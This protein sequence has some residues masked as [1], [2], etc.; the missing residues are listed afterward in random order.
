MAT[1]A[2][3]QDAAELASK[4]FRNFD[5]LLWP[6]QGSGAVVAD[7]PAPPAVL[8]LGGSTFMGRELVQRLVAKPARVCVVNRGRK[9]WGTDDP[10][11]GKA[12][13]L[14][15]DRRDAKSFAHL[16]DLAT[17]RLGTRWDLVADFSA[18]N[19]D[20]IRA[21]LAGLQG[22]FDKYVYI[23]SDSVYE[24]SAWA[25]E[26]WS[27][28]KGT[29]GDPYVAEVDSERPADTTTQKRLRK[30]DSYGDGKLEAE[31]ALAAGLAEHPATSRGVALRLP[32][33]IGPFDDTLR[34]WAYWHW[35]HAGPDEPPQ[36]PDAKAGKRPRRMAECSEDGGKGAQGGYPS[37]SA[38][39]EDPVPLSFVYSQDVARFIIDLLSLELPRDA[40]V[41]DAVNLACE[42]QPDLCGFLGLL[43]AAAGLPS[44][45]KLVMKAGPKTFLPSVDR[46]WNLSCKRMLDVYRFKPTPLADVL[47]SCASWFRDG[48]SEFPR[49]ALRAAMKLPAGAR[50]PAIQSAGLTCT[51][52][53]SSSSSESDSPSEVD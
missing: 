2:P 35:L 39:S 27:P 11:N 46:P 3:K 15:A 51:P 7:S 13:R 52:S 50:Q 9:Y 53:S 47:K 23:S 4:H 49:D 24:V 41:C 38:N 45:P 33:V 6:S 29:S 26:G 25:G 1:S 40:P 42:Q 21:A 44:P 34:L 19:G 17:R 8:V 43:A 48:C 28:R 36:V 20:D 22:R 32:D 18:Y 5:A 14:I 16:L 31:E 12:A 30:A 37:A 10:S